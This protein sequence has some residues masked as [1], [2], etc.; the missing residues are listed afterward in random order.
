MGYKEAVIGAIG[1]LI[2]GI[3]L[4]AFLISQ[5]GNQMD[6]TTKGIFTNFIPILFLLAGAYTGY[7]YDT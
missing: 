6:P 5:I 2:I 7:E 4:M 3:I 1:G